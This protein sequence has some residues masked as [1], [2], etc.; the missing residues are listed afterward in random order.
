[1]AKK[2]SSVVRDKAPVVPG[3]MR[4]SR[5][6][7]AQEARWRAESDMDALARAEEIRKDKKR[8]S[9]AQAVAREKIDCMKEVAGPRRK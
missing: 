3:M 7:A 8:L 1:M 9:A 6:A 4:S 5:E 2:S